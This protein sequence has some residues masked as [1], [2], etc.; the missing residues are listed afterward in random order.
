[1]LCALV[2][3]AGAEPTYPCFRVELAPAIDGAVLEDAAW[4]QVPGVTGFCVLGGGYTQAKQTTAFA[5]HDSRSLYV[6]MVCE[7]PEI[8][9]VQSKMRDGDELWLEDGVEV[10]VQTPSGAIYQFAVTAGG[11]RRGVEAVAG[12]VG[13]DA[14]AHRGADH[15]SVELAVPF[16]LLHARPEDGGWRVAFCRNIWTTAAGGD[17]FTSWPALRA[18][19][20]EPGSFAR[21]ELR[22]GA[23]SAQQGAA[24]EQALNADYRAHLVG[25]VNIAAAGAEQYIGVLRRA[26]RDEQSAMRAEAR[27]VVM[28]WWRAQRLA[29][30]AAQ[31]PIARLREVATMSTDLAQ[32]S[33]VLAYRY[34]IEELLEG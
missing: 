16:E 23:A 26:A 3:V 8:A 17:R 2:A 30:T 25:Q 31:A 33:E 24:A 21:L 9:R 27:E 28:A 32:R 20:R 14:A 22:V 13:W 34:L 19:F 1:M 4:S 11:A 10:F 5:C 18:A 6:A 15:Y 7:E 12:N 29:G